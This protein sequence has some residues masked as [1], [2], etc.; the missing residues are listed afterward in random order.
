MI[1]YYLK[2]FQKKI[3]YILPTQKKHN[4]KKTRCSAHTFWRHLTNWEWDGLLAYSGKP[5]HLIL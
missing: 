2:L 3:Y 1:H 5:E 4:L